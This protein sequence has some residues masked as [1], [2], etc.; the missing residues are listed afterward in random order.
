MNLA[1]EK[2]KILYTH[3]LHG[4]MRLRER[5]LAALAIIFRF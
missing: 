4:G 2:N 1:A 3:H 5:L